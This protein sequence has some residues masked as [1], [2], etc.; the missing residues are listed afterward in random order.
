MCISSTL[1]NLRGRLCGSMPIDVLVK[2]HSSRADF[3]RV[4]LMLAT[5]LRDDLTAHCISDQEC[6]AEATSILQ[7]A[8]DS[9]VPSVHSRPKMKKKKLKAVSQR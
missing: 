8:I 2:C 4:V 5:A 1:K 7:F 6:H 9:R 3:D